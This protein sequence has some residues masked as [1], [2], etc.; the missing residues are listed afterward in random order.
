[1]TFRGLRLS[2]YLFKDK[3]THCCNNEFVF[4][5]IVFVEATLHRA[6]K[7]SNKK[8]NKHLFVQKNIPYFTALY[9]RLLAHNNSLPVFRRGFFIV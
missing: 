3:Y 7:K 6:I 4:G 1:M 9:N 8:R 5:F 2:I